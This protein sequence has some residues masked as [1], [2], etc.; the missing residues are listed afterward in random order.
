MNI[1]KKNI[2]GRRNHKHPNSQVW[3]H[4]WLCTRTARRIGLREVNKRA[5]RSEKDRQGHVRLRDH[6]RKFA[7]Y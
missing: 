5:I 1:L 7:F 4:C 2:L 3:E 6:D